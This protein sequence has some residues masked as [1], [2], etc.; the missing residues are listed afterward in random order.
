MLT[1]SLAKQAKKIIDATNV[2]GFRTSLSCLISESTAGSMRAGFDPL[3]AAA[4]SNEG[5]ALLGELVGW[6]EGFI[7]EARMKLEA[8][9]MS[10]ET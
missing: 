3:K 9:S 6:L 10:K 5:G 4:A 2:D 7:R 1:R 8:E